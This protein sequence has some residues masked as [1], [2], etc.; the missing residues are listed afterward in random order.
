MATLCAKHFPRLPH[1]VLINKSTGEVLWVVEH[2]GHLSSNS[3]GNW[4]AGI[5]GK[6]GWRQRTLSQGLWGQQKGQHGD[7][8]LLSGHHRLGL[9]R[10]RFA[11]S[12]QDA[13]ASPFPGVPDTSA[14]PPF[15][16][17]LRTHQRTLGTQF[18]CGK[19]LWPRSGFS[20][21]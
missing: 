18:P 9:G 19:A 7:G 1:P 13:G 15:L 21:C 8:L 20:A 17:C 3:P 2:R 14:P 11:K 16:N 12:A 10:G 5:R 6:A 4:Q